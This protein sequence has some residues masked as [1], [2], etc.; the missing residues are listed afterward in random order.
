MQEYF[1]QSIDEVKLL[2]YINRRAHV[3]LRRSKAKGSEAT[4]AERAAA[5]GASRVLRLID[6][7]YYKEHL[8][9]VTEVRS[10]PCEVN[11]H[12]VLMLIWVRGICWRS[13]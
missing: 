11:R 6:F 4:A 2:E 12:R 1:D 13:S 5:D 7:F 9:I 10:K 8:F 3:A